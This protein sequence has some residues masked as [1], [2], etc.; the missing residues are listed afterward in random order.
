MVLK[1]T[2]KQFESVLWSLE[3]QSI[4]S[5]VCKES[6]M[7]V[8]YNLVNRHFLFNKY[9][10]YIK[11]SWKASF[12][13]ERYLQNE[14]CNQTKDYLYNAHIYIYELWKINKFHHSQNGQPYAF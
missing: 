4:S 12:Y 14:Q 5:G 8:K 2:F 6:K 13:T 7:P 9:N 3:N 10:I 11:F 1:S